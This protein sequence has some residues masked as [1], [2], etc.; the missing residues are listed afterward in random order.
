[1]PLTLIRREGE[2]MKMRFILVAI[3]M[4]CVAINLV[5]AQTLQMAASCD[6]MQKQLLEIIAKPGATEA[7][8]IRQDLGVDIF[9]TCDSPAGK[10]TCFQCLDDRQKLRTL[11]VI[12]KQDTKRFE[13]LGFGCRCKDEK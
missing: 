11:Q 5:S 2:D 7:E 10:V 1:L 3:V 12:Q 4:L 9:V 6:K 8:K 13:L